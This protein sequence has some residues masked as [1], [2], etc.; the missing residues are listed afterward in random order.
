[1]KKVITTL[2]AIG[3]LT[4]SAQAND[5]QY[6]PF[7]G[8]Y[9]DVLVTTHYDAALTPYAQVGANTFKGPAAIPPNFIGGYN[10]DADAAANGGWRLRAPSP[11]NVGGGAA[12][13]MNSN[14][15]FVTDVAGANNAGYTLLS[16]LSPSTTYTLAVWGAVG[17]G[18]TNPKDALQFSFDQGASWG[19]V[20]DATEVSHPTGGGDWLT[21]DSGFVNGGIGT[22]TGALLKDASPDGGGDRRFRIIIGEFTTGAADTSF[23]IGFRDPGYATKLDGN[24]QGNDRGR[25]DGFAVAE[26]DL[27]VIPEPT[28]FALAGLGAAAL[29]IFRRR[30]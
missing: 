16:G 1:M 27:S 5:A 30:S 10:S 15:Y 29:L 28:T 3:A 24:K 12:Y 21:H 25:I 13:C 6:A 9:T 22:D 11:W 18:E 26:G 7:I 23:W 8:N 19:T 14:L 2:V 4:I 20:Y 17:P